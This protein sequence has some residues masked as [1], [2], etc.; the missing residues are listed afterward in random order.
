M[1]QAHGAGL[2][3]E[4]DAVVT[5]LLSD[6]TRPGSSAC[7]Q[8]FVG[9]YSKSAR[10][11]S[12]VRAAARVGGRNDGRVSLSLMGV[13]YPFAA[14]FTSRQYFCPENLIFFPLSR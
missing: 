1:L 7:N 5:R 6:S 10:L 2:W 4:W 9:R 8:E 12:C 3:K 13:G 11:R 14:G